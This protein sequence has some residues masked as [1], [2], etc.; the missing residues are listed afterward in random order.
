MQCDAMHA[1][2]KRS[3]GRRSIA[4]LCDSIAAALSLHCTLAVTNLLRACARVR[5]RV[6]LR[7]WILMHSASVCLCICLSVCLSLAATPS[8]S[9]R[10]PFCTSRDLRTLTGRCVSSP[11]GSSSNSPT[12]SCSSAL[13]PGDGFGVTA[14]ERYLRRCASRKCVHVSLVRLLR[15]FEFNVQKVREMHCLRSVVDWWAN[16]CMHP[17]VSC[18]VRTQ[19]PHRQVNNGATKMDRRRHPSIIYFTFVLA[20]VPEIVSV[21]S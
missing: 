11:R 14:R 13:A 9:T 1:A 10:S 12:R 5:V 18:T 7:A 6:R 20:R 19:L 2:V 3:E 17:Q 4:R 15:A 21:T 8:L 16:G